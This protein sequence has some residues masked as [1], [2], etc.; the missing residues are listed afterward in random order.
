MLIQNQES[1]NNLLC[2]S[3]FLDETSMKKLKDERILREL[4]E[5]KIKELD[6]NIPIIVLS[7]HS[8]KEKLLKA[9]DLGI[10]KY[11]IKPFV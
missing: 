3:E 11:F 2:I 9:I 5:Q 10:N 7:A 4:E 6:E 8:D 1:L